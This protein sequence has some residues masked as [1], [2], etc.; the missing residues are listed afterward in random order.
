MEK[1][2]LLRNFS[3]FEPRDLPKQIEL[4][5]LV[6]IYVQGMKAKLV[7]KVQKYIHLIAMGHRVLFEC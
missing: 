1:K 4:K 3:F 5:G 7:F 2:Y 6:D